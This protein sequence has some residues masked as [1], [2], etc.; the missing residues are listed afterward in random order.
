MPHL[1]GPGTHAGYR[2]P[3]PGHMLDEHQTKILRVV[4]GE[5]RKDNPGESHAAKS[6]CARIAWGAVNRTR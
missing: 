6:K 1:H 4:Y 3:P 5:C 2:S